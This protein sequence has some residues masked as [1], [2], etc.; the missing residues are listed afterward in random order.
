MHQRRL[1]LRRQFRQ[2]RAA[3]ETADISRPGWIYPVSP[4]PT[5]DRGE[6]AHWCR[7]QRFGFRPPAKIGQPFTSQTGGFVNFEAA[8]CFFTSFGAV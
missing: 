4:E 1:H 8:T 3:A 7:K 2:D 6:H 5:A